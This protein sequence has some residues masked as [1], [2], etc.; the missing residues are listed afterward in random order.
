[1]KR[2]YLL[3]LI[4]ITLPTLGADPAPNTKAWYD[5]NNYVLVMFDD[6]TGIGA[7]YAL[8]I[9]PMPVDVCHGELDMLASL[10]QQQ[11]PPNAR[12]TF[13]RCTYSTSMNQLGGYHCQVVKRLP[14][15]GP[16]MPN[17]QQWIYA[18]A[19]A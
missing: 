6:G 3:S 11:M 13:K 1:M 2:L 9:G 5:A 16:A 15:N 18:C 7:G 12:M 8:V 10:F 14:M 4:A 19:G 17:A